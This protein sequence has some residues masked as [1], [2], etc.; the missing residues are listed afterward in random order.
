V[1]PHPTPSAGF[2][3]QVIAPTLV[4]PKIAA[5]VAEIK[6]ALPGANHFTVLH[7]DWCAMM[8]EKS[9]ECNC[10]PDVMPGAIETHRGMS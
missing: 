8:N 2:L 3:R 6:R 10:D 7:D 1:K 4:P 9:A 5:K